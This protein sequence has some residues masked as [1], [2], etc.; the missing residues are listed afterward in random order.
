MRCHK[1]LGL[2][3]LII[4]GLMSENVHKFTDQNFDSDV[5]KSNIPVLIDFWA[6]WCG[7]CKAIAPVIDE[8][9]G[10]YNGKVKVGKVDVD[11]NQDTAMKYG[12]RSIPTLLIMKDGKVVNQ[13]VG[14]V[15]KGNITTMLD[16]II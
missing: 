16:E 5:S 8:I 6:S 9:A 10:E 13:I 15:P 14:A 7:P 1:L 4:G 12:V 2:F 11:Q 3:L